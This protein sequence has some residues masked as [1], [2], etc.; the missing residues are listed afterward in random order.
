LITEHFEDG[1]HRFRRI[2]ERGSAAATR[3][4]LAAEKGVTAG[5]AAYRR[6]Y[7]ISVS[8]RRIGRKLTSALTESFVHGRNTVAVP[9]EVALGLWLREAG[10]GRR[11]GPVP[12]LVK[13]ELRILMPQVLHRKRAL[14]DRGESATVAGEMAAGEFSASSGL[15]VE[16]ILWLLNHRG[17]WR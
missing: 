6:E 13:I 14:M 17:Q 1:S 16:R 11:S 4:R 10:G 3:V 9:I 2:S 7:G 15:S 8:H 12:D 5:R